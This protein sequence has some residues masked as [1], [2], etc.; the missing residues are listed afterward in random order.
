MC[1]ELELT[2]N[3][4]HNSMVLCSSPW[5]GTSLCC[6]PELTLACAGLLA[7]GLSGGGW[8]LE[9]SQYAVH[10]NYVGSQK[11][12]VPCRTMG[13]G[14]AALPGARRELT[15]TASTMLTQRPQRLRPATAL[16]AA[17]CRM[18]R[19]SRALLQVNCLGGTACRNVA[20]WRED[21]V[22]AMPCCTCLAFGQHVALLA[23]WSAGRLHCL[24]ECR[25]VVCGFCLKL[26]AVT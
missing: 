16:R 17:T 13:P 21:Y 6:M 23:L 8:W 14:L 11:H 25:A 22:L 4:W 20:H 15:M 18:R 9:A 3:L 26:N 24:C 1:H 12:C 2:M 7:L 10:R 5:H 19:R